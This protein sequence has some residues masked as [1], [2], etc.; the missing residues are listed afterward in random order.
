MSGGT[1]L[2]DSLSST[3]SSSPTNLFS[4]SGPSLFGSITS[5]SNSNSNAVLPGTGYPAASNSNSGGLSLFPHSGTSSASQ[6]NSPSTPSQ[7]LDMS[8]AT[9]LAGS[10][11]SV[12]AATSGDK[13]V[14]KPTSE[15]IEAYKADKFILGKIP[16]H[17]PPTE[18]I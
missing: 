17:A 14:H 10:G 3:N 16:E 1:G 12:P 15:E 9:P 4:A 11:P 8:T 13:S 5:T 6:L 2:F 18:F 7:Q